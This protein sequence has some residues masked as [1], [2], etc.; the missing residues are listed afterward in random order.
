MV[1]SLGCENVT[2]NSISFNH[3]DKTNLKVEKGRKT[4]GFLRGKGIQG[5]DHEKVEK[6]H[7]GRIID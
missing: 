7:L 2:L 4:G 6:G 3:T 5:I 1:S